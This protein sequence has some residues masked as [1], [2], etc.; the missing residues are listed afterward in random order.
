MNQTSMCLDPHQK[1][2]VRL[3]P[4]SMFMPSSIFFTDRSKAVLFVDPFI[5]FNVCFVFGLGVSNARGSRSLP[6][7]GS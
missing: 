4:L 1:L 7:Y 6:D 3:I 2:R 5:V